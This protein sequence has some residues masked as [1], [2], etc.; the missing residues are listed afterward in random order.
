[1]SLN[2]RRVKWMFQTVA[3]TF[4]L[5]PDKVAEDIEE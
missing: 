3:D 5:N 2:N 1:M 4:G